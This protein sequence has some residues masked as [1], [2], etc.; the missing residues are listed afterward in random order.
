MKIFKYLLEQD[1]TGLQIVQ[2][3]AGARML[4]VGEQYGELYAWAMVHENATPVNYKFFVLGTG[5]DCGHLEIVCN[6]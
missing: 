5:I 2:M 6:F 4:H 1:P 3:P